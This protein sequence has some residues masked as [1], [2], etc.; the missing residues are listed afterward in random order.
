LIG[1][2]GFRPNGEFH[3]GQLTDVAAASV[4]DDAHTSVRAERGCEQVAQHGVGIW[5]THGHDYDIA[6]LAKT[7][8]VMHHDV[9]AGMRQKP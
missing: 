7:G 6:L 8:G 1:R 4:D 3:G 5:G 9:V 2:D